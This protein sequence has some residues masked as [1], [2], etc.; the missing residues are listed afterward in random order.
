M[1]QES[2]WVACMPSSNNRLVLRVSCLSYSDAFDNRLD[3]DRRA[4]CSYNADWMLEGGSE[5]LSPFY[6]FIVHTLPGTGS[7]FREQHFKS[8]F[9]SNALFVVHPLNDF[10]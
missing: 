6:W 10:F 8:D 4:S 2:I 3:T 5:F 7:A 9:K 1:F